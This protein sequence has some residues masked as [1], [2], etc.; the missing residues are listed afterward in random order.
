MTPSLAKTGRLTDTELTH[1]LCH[2]EMHKC[3][4]NSEEF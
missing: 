3:A 2:P 1:P 4:S